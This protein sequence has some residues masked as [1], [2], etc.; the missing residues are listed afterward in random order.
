MREH[1]LGYL[2]GALEPTEQ[3]Q[4][5]AQLEKDAQLRRDCRLLRD[6]LFPLASDEHYD[7]PPALATRTCRYVAEYDSPAFVGF[8][9]V[10]AWRLSDMLVAAGILVTATLLLFPA[11]AN[12]RFHSRIDAC[13]DNLRQ[14]GQ[15]L[16]SY[17]QQHGGGYPA[18]PKSGNLSAAGVYAPTLVDHKLVDDPRVF[19][20]PASELASRGSF[21]VPT[22]ND[23]RTASPELLHGLRSTMGGSYGYTLGYKQDGK[24]HGAG[25]RRRST[26]AV[27]ADTPDPGASRG[28]SFNHGCCG[29]NVLFEDGHVSFLKRCQLTD[30]G[31]DIFTNILGQVGPGIGEDDSVV[32]PSHIGPGLFGEE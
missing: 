32:A 10:G 12:S 26:L 17:S 14:L 28:N 21:Q 6:C 1:L 2:I 31:D 15:A 22:L 9:G 30:S 29:Q 24:Y 27:M 19:V 20:C 25:N 11:V 8:G 23:L 4:V 13:R 5:S 16:A 3:A 18:V 7:P